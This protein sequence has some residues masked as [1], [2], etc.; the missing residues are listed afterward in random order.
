MNLCIY[1]KPCDKKIRIKTLNYLHIGT[2][3]V[4]ARV[5]GQRIR[6]VGGLCDGSAGGG[7]RRVQ[8][9]LGPK[10]KSMRFIM[11]H[12]VWV[13]YVYFNIESLINEEDVEYYMNEELKN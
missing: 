3:E 7:G 10:P 11:D 4:G 13:L 9:V 5:S 2:P 12:T 6:G 8:G 1:L